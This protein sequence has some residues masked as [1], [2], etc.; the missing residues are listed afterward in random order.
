MVAEWADKWSHTN[1]EKGVHKVDPIGV[2]LYDY[3]MKHGKVYKFHALSWYVPIEQPPWVFRFEPPGQKKK[4]IFLITPQARLTAILDHTKAMMQLLKDKN[5]WRVD[6]INEAI[7]DGGSFSLR[8]YWTEM[9]GV[10]AIVDVFLAARQVS[11]KA[12]L[13]YND[14]NTSITNGKSDAMFK[15]FQD[16]RTINP[17]AV[18]DEVGFQYH[19]NARDMDDAWF[20]KFKDNMKRF[21]TE[22]KPKNNPKGMRVNLSEVD[23]RTNQ[24]A[25][26]DTTKRLQIVAEAYYKTFKIGLS[27]LSICN[28]I[29]L[30]NFDDTVNWVY[31]PEDNEWMIEAWGGYPDQKKD[32]GA[33]PWA[34]FNPHPAVQRITEALKEVVAA[35]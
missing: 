2:A 20:V 7:E 33:V 12:I 26:T 13:V 11:P 28:N 34:G 9:G 15:M 23:I 30:W 18:P 29:C 27:D 25:E 8:P 5:V 14:Y 1:P 6:V 32:P 10:S 21:H 24:L 31:K 4:G 3:A 17:E 19:E 35:N 16:M 22:F